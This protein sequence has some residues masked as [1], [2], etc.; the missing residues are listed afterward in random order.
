[1]LTGGRLTRMIA[2]LPHIEVMETGQM[3]MADRQGFQPFDPADRGTPERE[4]SSLLNGAQ[5]WTPNVGSLLIVAPHPDDEVLGA[6]GLIHAWTA[7]GQ[8]VTLLSVTDG[9]ASDPNRPGLA[10]IRQQE[11]RAALRVLTPAHVKIIRIGIPD[12]KVSD[13][14]NRLRLMLEEHLTTDGTLI[15]PYEFDGHP[16][17]DIA[18]RVCRDLARAAHI[19]LARYPVWTWHHTNPDSVKSLPWGKFA[20]TR[21]AQ[22]AKARALRCFES[23]LRPLFGPPIIPEHVLSYFQR[24]YE[25]F[26]L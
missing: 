9:E 14:A 4:W 26:V 24:P 13:H 10:Q 25:A 20:L 21:S 16:D 6:G 5:A 22:R 12:G 19:A 18:G 8:P 17:H 11:L 1:M 3:A 23:Q 15:A 7:S 2:G